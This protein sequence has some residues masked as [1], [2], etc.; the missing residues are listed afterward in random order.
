[1]TPRRMRLPAHYRAV[2]ERRLMEASQA[3]G[4]LWSVV[5]ECG[6]NE[7]PVF[8]VAEG[9][10]FCVIVTNLRPERVLEALDA[11]QP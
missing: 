6:I 4:S 9:D 2:V 5:S 1:V 10:D 11:E 8:L 3:A 7:Y